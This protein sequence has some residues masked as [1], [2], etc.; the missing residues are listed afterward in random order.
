MI[1]RLGLIVSAAA[2]VSMLWASAASAATE[3]GST[4]Q[5]NASQPS[6]SLLQVQ[7]AATN[8]LPITAPTGGV[9]TRWSLDNQIPTDPGQFPQALQVYRQAGPGNAFTLISQTTETPLAAGLNSFPTRLPVQAGDRL[10]IHGATETMY[11]LTS[12]SSEEDND[13]VGYIEGEIQPGA[14]QT[15]GQDSPFRIP[16]RAAIEPDADNDGF[17]DETQDQC[18]QNAAIQTPCPLVALTAKRQ[19]KDGSVVIVV[20]SDTPAP[21][22]VNGV[23]KL[24]K[25]KKAKINGG[26]KNLTPGVLGKF[27]LKFTDKV[28]TKLEELSPKQKLTLKVTVTGTNVAGQA[29]TKKLKVKLKGQAS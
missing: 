25:G 14:T 16:V 18:P 12:G 1:R 2:T 29:T 21:V 11:C 19:V 8:G 26:S 4:C 28:K 5:A 6:L 9:I 20:S 17:G 15:F 10:G 23:V 22:T 13:V 24:G 3:F 7:Q 27:R